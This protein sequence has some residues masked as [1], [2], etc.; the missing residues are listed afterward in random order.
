MLCDS[1]TAVSLV[2]S[3]QLRSAHSSSSF[4]YRSWAS[5]FSPTQ[6]D[7]AGG[8]SS[9]DALDMVEGGREGPRT[10]VERRGRLLRLTVTQGVVWERSDGA[11]AC[12]ALRAEKKR[13]SKVSLR[14]LIPTKKL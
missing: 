6:C 5:S 3:R 8:T 1:L 10:T 4:E 12:V 7:S 13:D 2:L 11:H 9:S 14:H